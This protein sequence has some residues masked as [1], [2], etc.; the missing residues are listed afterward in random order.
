[1]KELQ[2]FIFKNCPFSFPFLSRVFSAHCDVMVKYSNDW[3]YPLQS[4][5]YWLAV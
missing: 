1:M 4:R 3:P 5:F 2:S